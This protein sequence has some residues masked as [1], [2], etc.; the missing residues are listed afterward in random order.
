MVEEDLPG[1]PRDEPDEVDCDADVSGASKS[2]EYPRNR[3]KNLP[4]T[5]EHK[6]KRSELG[7]EENPPDQGSG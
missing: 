7:E 6:V 1:E 4:N 5:S 2:N 3:S